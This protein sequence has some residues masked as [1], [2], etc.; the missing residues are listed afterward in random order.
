MPDTNDYCYLE[1]YKVTKDPSLC[2]K[3]VDNN[4]KDSSCFGDVFQ[5]VR[6]S[7][8]VSVCS[9]INTQIY[10]DYCYNIIAVG[11]SDT[12]FCQNIQDSTVKSFCLELKYPSK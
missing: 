11:K 4:M 3:I 1:I 12:S 5:Q 7:L 8:D 2:D 10:K 6:S 9:K